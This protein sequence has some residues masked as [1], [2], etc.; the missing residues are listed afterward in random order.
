MITSPF[1]STTFCY[2]S[3]PLPVLQKHRSLLFH[4]GLAPNI[5][6][7]ACWHLLPSLLPRALRFSLFSQILGVVLDFITLSPLVTCIWQNPSP[8]EIQIFVSSHTVQEL[9][10][11]FLAYALRSTCCFKYF[12]L[13]S[14]PLVLLLSVYYEPMTSFQ[15]HNEASK[16]GRKHIR[17]NQETCVLNSHVTTPPQVK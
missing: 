7:H 5:F 16:Y 13:P 6:L 8:G 1:L 15:S 3:F 17:S 12:P 9:W 10:Y 4:T 11:T 2:S 14:R